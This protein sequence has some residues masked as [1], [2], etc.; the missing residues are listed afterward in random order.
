VADETDIV[1]SEDVAGATCNVALVEVNTA[2]EGARIGKP[3][4]NRVRWPI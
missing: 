3:E 4:K 2:D 1:G